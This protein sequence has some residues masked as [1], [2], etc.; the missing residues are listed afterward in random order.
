MQHRLRETENADRTGWHTLAVTEA[1]DGSFVSRS[2]EGVTLTKEQ[3]NVAADTLKDMMVRANH[4]SFTAALTLIWRSHLSCCTRHAFVVLS[5][6][7]PSLTVSTCLP[8]LS[9][10]VLTLYSRPIA[11]LTITH[12]VPKAH[13]VCYTGRVIAQLTVT[14]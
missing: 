1:A 2:L 9:D 6:S 10:R 3:F 13:P 7:S 4:L 5:H 8:S 14:H 12:C 11:Q